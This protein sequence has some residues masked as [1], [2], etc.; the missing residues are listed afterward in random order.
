MSI[1]TR[2]D[3]SFF[4]TILIISFLLFRRLDP[5]GIFTTLFL[6]RKTRRYLIEGRNKNN[7]DYGYKR[8][9]KKREHRGYGD[10]ASDPTLYVP[11]PTSIRDGFHEPINEIVQR[12]GQH[13]RQVEEDFYRLRR[14]LRDYYLDLDLVSKSC[15]CDV[16]C[17]HSP[18]RSEPTVDS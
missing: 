2:D 14:L 7:V 1:V 13:I 3:H 16:N 17:R 11:Q 10:M 18:E 5:F 8:G 15:E 6:H 9:K 12:Q 4:L